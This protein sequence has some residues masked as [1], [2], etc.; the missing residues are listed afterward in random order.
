[1]AGAVS[2]SK[3]QR[4]LVQS[5]L[6]K[7]AAIRQHVVSVKANFDRGLNFIRS[8]VSANVEEFRSYNFSL[9]SLLVGGALGRGSPLVGEAAFEAYLVSGAK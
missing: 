1:M 3:Q 6:E 5:Q 7:E 9:A 4:A 2:L 8:L